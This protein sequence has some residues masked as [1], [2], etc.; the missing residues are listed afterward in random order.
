MT[1]KHM[2]DD[3]DDDNLRCGRCKTFIADIFLIQKMIR[4]FVATRACQISI[5][6]HILGKKMLK[7]VVETPTFCLKDR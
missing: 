7:I 3:D 5:Q 4:Q 1:D 6:L 2:Y